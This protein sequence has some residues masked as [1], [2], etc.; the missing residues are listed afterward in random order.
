MMPQTEHQQL[1]HTIPVRDPVTYE[2]GT[3]D[4]A[5]G[6]PEKSRSPA[7]ISWSFRRRWLRIEQ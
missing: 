2:R 3:A 1:D 7:R 4:G 5:S 6:C